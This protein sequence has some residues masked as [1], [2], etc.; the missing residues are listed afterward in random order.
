M[1]TSSFYAYQ[2][3]ATRWLRD[4]GTTPKPY[5]FRLNAYLV[6]PHDGDTI[7]VDVDWGKRRWEHDQPIRLVGCAARELRD[8]GGSQA[9]VALAARIQEGT[10]VGL[11]TLK[12]DKFAPRWDCIVE[13]YVGGVLHD[14]AADLIADGWAVPWNGRGTQPKPAWPRVVA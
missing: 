14:L 10:W 3:A 8:D 7:I 6:E 5:E 13:Y 2:D 12:D 4:S 9:Q 11:R 1:V